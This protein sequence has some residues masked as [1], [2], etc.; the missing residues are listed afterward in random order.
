MTGKEQSLN[1]SP[2]SAH[3][4]NVS[5]CLC[6]AFSP[7]MPRE[8]THPHECMRGV[9]TTQAPVLCAVIG[10]HEN[11]HQFKTRRHFLKKGLDRQSEGVCVSDC[12]R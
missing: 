11:Q 9:F 6:F 8:E 7:P 5:M 12:E 4:P 3:C 1:I 10:Y 2:M